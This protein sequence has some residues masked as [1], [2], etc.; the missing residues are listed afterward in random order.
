MD[1]RIKNLINAFEN[2]GWQFSGSVDIASDWWFDDMLELTL[3]WQPVGTN[4]YLTLLTDPAII[5][6]K[7]TWCIGISIKIPTDKDFEFEER[8]TMKDL[9]KIDL[10]KLVKRINVLVS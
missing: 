8:I 10:Q 4:L 7:V 3:T 2:N 1:I 5:D 9:T 6:K